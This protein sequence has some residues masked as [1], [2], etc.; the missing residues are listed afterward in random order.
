MSAN[1]GLGRWRYV[2]EIQI[3]LSDCV[4]Y[5]DRLLVDVL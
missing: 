3:A 2:Y 4:I 5:L 1:K